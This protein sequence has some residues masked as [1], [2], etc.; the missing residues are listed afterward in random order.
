MKK[1]PGKG[2]EQWL[3]DYFDLREELDT[4]IQQKIDCVKKSKFEFA[5]AFRDK[6]RKLWRRYKGLCAKIKANL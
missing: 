6:E 1:K 3:R 5:A 2:I 4:V